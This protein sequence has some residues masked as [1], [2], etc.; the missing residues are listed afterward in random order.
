M[1]YLLDLDE[2]TV[3]YFPVYDD[4]DEIYAEKGKI[5]GSKEK[6][7]TL[8]F[9]QSYGSWQEKIS[10]SGNKATLIDSSGFDWDYRITDVEKVRKYTQKGSFHISK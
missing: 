2:N 4:S 5:S 10:F 3:L 6:G 8:K 1:Y 7:F 9:D